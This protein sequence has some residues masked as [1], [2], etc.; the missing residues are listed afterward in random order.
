MLQSYNFFP[1]KKMSNQNIDEF[2]MRRAIQ[3]A[4]NGE[5]TAHPNPLVGAVIVGPT[6][7]PSPK[8]RGEVTLIINFNLYKSN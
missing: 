5:L 8:G 6:P 1:I 2:W 4:R 7:G 3:L